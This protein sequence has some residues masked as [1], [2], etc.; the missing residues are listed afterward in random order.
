MARY[1]APAGRLT[2]T[3]DG[4][5]LDGHKLPATDAVTVEEIDSGFHIV[6]LQLY[7]KTIEAADE[8]RISTSNATIYRSVLTE[9][10]TA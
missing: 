4:V 3:P 2:I 8:N 1:T 10:V 7:V 5:Y 9:A 6:S